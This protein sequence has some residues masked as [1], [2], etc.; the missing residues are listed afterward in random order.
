MSLDVLDREL[1]R[2]RATNREDRAFDARFVDGRRAR[3]TAGFAPAAM[4]GTPSTREEYA[5]PVSISGRR[6]NAFRAAT[7]HRTRIGITINEQEVAK[8]SLPPILFSLGCSS[9]IAARLVA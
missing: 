3:T 7:G 5:R 9:G 8:G 6:L 4:N 2:G 1:E